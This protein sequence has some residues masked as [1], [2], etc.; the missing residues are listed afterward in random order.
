VRARAVSDSDYGHLAML[1]VREYEALTWDIFDL[2]TAELAG[3]LQ[4]VEAFG[5]N[6]QGTAQENEMCVLCACARAR[7]CVF[8]LDATTYL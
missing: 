1:S 3:H 8:F 2:S 4:H 5:D 6:E 7:V